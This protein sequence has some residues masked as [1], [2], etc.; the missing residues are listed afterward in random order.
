MLTP[1]P[2]VTCLWPCALLPQIHPA[3]KAQLVASTP[4]LAVGLLHCRRAL[5][6]P[7]HW[8]TTHQLVRAFQGNGLWAASLSASG[9]VSV[10]R[11]ASVG[12]QEAG[13]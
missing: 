12:S 10:S 2:V 1:C 3:P 13:P 6:H 7:E 5:V 11:G 8:S 9:S 4:A